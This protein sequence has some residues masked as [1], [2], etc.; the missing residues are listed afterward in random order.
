MYSS[1]PFI[2][3]STFLIILSI[4]NNRALPPQ[5]SIQRIRGT[6]TFLLL[7][8]F[9]SYVV[10]HSITIVYTTILRAP[11]SLPNSNRVVVVVLPLCCHGVVHALLQSI[12][13]QP[14]LSAH[15]N[16]QPV[17]PSN[18]HNANAN[19][20]IWSDHPSANLEHHQSLFLET[21]SPTFAALKT[22]CLVRSTMP[23][24]QWHISVACAST[25]DFDLNHR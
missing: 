9:L 20:S 16:V 23:I 15:R 6:R 18:A 17:A 12:Q 3:Y 1:A 19:I 5:K 11:F 13:H 25:V 24:C 14:I 7:S 4:H 22:V 21:F 10:I 8:C 2:M